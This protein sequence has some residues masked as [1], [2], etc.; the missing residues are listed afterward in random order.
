M[1]QRTGQDLLITGATGT[2]GSAFARACEARGLSYQL[3][4]RETF[5]IANPVSVG[6]ALDALE[7]W[8]VINTAGYVRVDDAESDVERCRRENTLGP[9]VL[10]AACAQRQIALVT[11]SSDLVFDG[12][13]SRPY[14]ESD[15]VGPLNVY[16]QTKA[17][18]ER[19]VA[20]LMPQA[21]I[22]RT[23]A[24]FGPWD[25]YNF[26]TVALRELAA[27][28]TFAAIS[29]QTISPTY[30]PHLTEATLD[31][32]IDGERGLWHLA[33]PGAVTWYAFA[34]QVAELAAID[35]RTLRPVSSAE[36]QTP[37]RK[38]RCS[39]LSSE[40]GV[41]LPPLATAL[42]AFISARS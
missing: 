26:A 5:D 2:L 11:F 3:T 13:T 6:T 19:Q 18:A 38:P 39:V 37:V 10:A 29:D 33:S 42:E 21:L 1:R 25:A 14:V 7:P 22:V 8:A 28:R 40:R 9:T 17:A 41:L 20:R 4:R 16:G 27:G 31:L 24:F 34:A 23:S 12:R 32:L 30:V 35:A 15:P 36:L